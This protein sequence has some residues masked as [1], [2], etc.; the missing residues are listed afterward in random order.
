MTEQEGGS[1]PPPEV[2][3]AQQS[4]APKPFQPS[5]IMEKED[6]FSGFNQDLQRHV[7]SLHRTPELVMT[8]D[9]L[10][11]RYFKIDEAVTEGK[12]PEE[13]A[14]IVLGKIAKRIEELESQTE[15]PKKEA[16]ETR[17][18]LS[19]EEEELLQ[20]AKEG[21][22]LSSEEARSFYSSLRDI[23]A[24]GI[25]KLPDIR[26][27]GE[28]KFKKIF[29]D[30]LRNLIEEQADQSFDQ[31]WRLVYPLEMAIMS[32]HP[33]VGEGETIPV[34]MITEEGKPET[35]DG[36]KVFKEI[37]PSSLRKE[38]SGELQ[39]Y[40]DI[41][42]Y[43]YIHRRVGGVTALIEAGTLLSRKTISTVLRPTEGDKGPF[44]AGALRWLEKIGNEVFEK[45]Q[46]LYTESY[47]KEN[48]TK[49][50]L[51]REI[52]EKEQEARDFVSDPKFKPAEGEEIPFWARRI[53]GGLYSGLHES[54]RHDLQIN[55][56]GDFFT[57]RLFHNSERVK[58]QWEKWGRPPCKDLYESLDLQ[59]HGFFEKVLLDKY[60]DNKVGFST[61]CNNLKIKYKRV[62]EKEK[63]I[64][65]LDLSNAQFE[66]INFTIANGEKQNFLPIASDEVKL[67]NLTLDDADKIRKMIMDPK[68]FIDEP[69]MATLKKA[70]EMFKHLKG[71]AR[72]DWFRRVCEQVVLLYMDTVHPQKENASPRSRNCPAQKIYPELV[73]W[74]YNEVKNQLDRMTPPLT[75][76]D[77]DFLLEKFIGSRTQIRQRENL[78]VA[79]KVGGSML[80][81]F[82]KALLGLK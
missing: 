69:S 81:E 9:Y 51:R 30:R 27:V 45:K 32:L 43:I 14:A 62:D 68:G 44:V 12:I 36:K 19:P 74:T 20:K 75:A 80:G 2:Q 46:S 3:K 28:E 39:A 40:R 26:E 65:G 6:E 78:R 60:E 47:K 50:E 49:E 67:V 71:K 24:E 72:S 29:R 35:K 58:E 82:I 37:D 77:E 79:T 73:P 23:E 16:F 38:L 31:N 53:A 64:V 18:K 15:A 42:N 7:R 4:E 17:R 61:F 8:P 11:E 34:P 63:R 59:V 55:E 54:A 52:G 10:R 57:D 25:P 70:Y 56:S 21:K 41:H 66:K 48:K 13:E 22:P 5:W 76:E 1:P 33:R